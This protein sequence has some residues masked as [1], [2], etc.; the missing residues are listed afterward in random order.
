LAAVA[1]VPNIFRT[2]EGIIDNWNHYKVEPPFITGFA[3]LLYTSREQNYSLFVKNNIYWLDSLTGPDFIL[4]I[5]EELDSYV[6]RFI[7]EPPKTK[8][9]DAAPVQ[10]VAFD[11]VRKFK[12]DYDDAP[13]IAFFKDINDTEIIVYPLKRDWNDNRI[14][15]ALTGV[16]DDFKDAWEKA[17]ELLQKDDSKWNK[18]MNVFWKDLEKRVKKRERKVKTISLGKTILNIL[19]EVKSMFKEYNLYKG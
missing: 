7:K 12:M 13:C 6:S 10:D 5:F 1:A 3:F 16:S 15:A 4:F 11:V 9:E 8:E 14:G 17:T 18:A 2:L 19:K